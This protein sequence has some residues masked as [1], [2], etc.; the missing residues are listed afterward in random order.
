MLGTPQFVEV[1]WAA[2]P[3]IQSGSSTLLPPDDDDDFNPDTASQEERERYKL[4]PCTKSRTANVYYY[5]VRD[6]WI[7]YS[8]ACL[9]ALFG[10]IAGAVAIH[11]G[12][13]G[14]VRDTRFSSIV[15]AT[16]GPALEKVRWDHNNSSSSGGVRNSVS[17]F[18]GGGKDG[19]GDDGGSVMRVSENVKRLRVGYGLLRR[20]EGF[21]G[22]D[23]NNRGH[24]RGRGSSVSDDNVI[25]GVYPVGMGT[26]TGSEGIP[27]KGYYY[28]FGLEGDV[29]QIP[30]RR[31]R[32][33]SG[34]I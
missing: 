28:G 20:G 30:R 4:Y 17:T 11:R 5:S 9:L 26:G 23:N 25:G 13:E 1:V 3:S 24:G 33:R 32:G 22:N 31:V 18:F 34:S 15:A 21:N 10:V 12:N 7:V 27:S 8:I 19:D 16:R 14:A 6:L 2:D 29:E